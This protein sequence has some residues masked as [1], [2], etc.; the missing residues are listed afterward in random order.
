MDKHIIDIFVPHKKIRKAYY[1]VSALL[2]LL[3]IPDLSKQNIL[4]PTKVLET[5]FLDKLLLTTIVLL[6]LESYAIYRLSKIYEEE[7]KN[8]IEEET[9]KLKAELTELKQQIEQSSQINA[10]LPKR[11]YGIV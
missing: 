2:L 4:W 6:M 11:N 5:W 10:P 8:R 1:L 7:S 9:K 3:W